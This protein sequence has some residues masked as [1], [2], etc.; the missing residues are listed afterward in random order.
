MV[1]GALCG[2][3]SA[4]ATC[5]S[6]LHV[7]VEG[8]ASRARDLVGYRVEVVLERVVRHEDLPTLIGLLT[9]L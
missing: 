6:F 7:R 1:P 5:K 2:T 9:G 4:A 3:V 8:R